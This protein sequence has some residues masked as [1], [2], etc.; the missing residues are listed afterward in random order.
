MKNNDYV[1]ESMGTLEDLL[2]FIGFAKSKTEA[3][4]QLDMNEITVIQPSGERFK[5]MSREVYKFNDGDILK[6]GRKLKRLVY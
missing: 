1:M 5:L 4:R 2:M 6:R 3:K